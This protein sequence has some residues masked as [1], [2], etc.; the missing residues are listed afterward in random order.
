MFLGITRE[1]FALPMAEM[2]DFEYI[3][4]VRLDFSTAVPLER[5]L[6]GRTV[7]DATFSLENE[8]DTYEH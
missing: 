8:K 3:L 4:R 1:I 6:M 5:Y 2:D 7:Q